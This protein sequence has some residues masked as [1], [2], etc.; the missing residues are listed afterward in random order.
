MNLVKYFAF[1]IPLLL[2]FE[3]V[4]MD[5]VRDQ[6]ADEPPPKKR[7]LQPSPVEKKAPQKEIRTLKREN[8]F[9][10]ELPGELPAQQFL[11][12]PPDVQTDQLK[13]KPTLKMFVKAVEANTPGLPWTTQLILLGENDTRGLTLPRGE[14]DT[15][16]L[17]FFISEGPQNEPIDIDVENIT[18]TPQTLIWHSETPD[19]ASPSKTPEIISPP[20]TSEI[21]SPFKKPTFVHRPHAPVKSVSPPK[22]KDQEEPSKSPPKKQNPKPVQNPQKKPPA[23]PPGL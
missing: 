18:G 3:G 17:T 20:K 22:Q 15:R 5:K 16:G 4:A 19:A 12:P 2:S 10:A 7:K 14:N 23:A 6:S 1:L 21:I 8:A 11:T 13:K 9:T